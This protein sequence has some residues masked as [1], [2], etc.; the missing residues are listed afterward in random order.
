MSANILLTP[1]T[2][3]T[4]RLRNLGQWR[5]AAVLLLQ[6]RE[7]GRRGT[8]RGIDNSW[9]SRQITCRISLSCRG[10]NDETHVGSFSFVLGLL[11]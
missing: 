1:L 2:M 10:E 7:H 11:G 5:V 8:N 3:S 4:W 9:P 6:F